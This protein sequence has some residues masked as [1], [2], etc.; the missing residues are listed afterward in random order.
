M[1]FDNQ[2]KEAIIYTEKSLAFWKK[3][4]DLEEDG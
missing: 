3:K 1:L 4:N 2:I